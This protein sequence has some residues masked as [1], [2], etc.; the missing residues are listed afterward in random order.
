MK[1]FFR[2][3]RIIF[4]IEKWLWKS[5]ICNLAGL[6]TSS[7]NVQKNFQTHFCDQ[8]E[9]FLSNSIDMVKIL[10][11]WWIE[12]FNNTP[13]QATHAYLINEY[14]YSELPNKQA[15]QDKRVCRDDFTIS[16]MSMGKDFLI[17]YSKNWKY[18]GFF[19]KKKLSIL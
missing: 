14:V 13:A 2:K 3:I 6:I 5:E 8:F 18:G 15:D 1:F 10:H 19:F 9:K 12:K 7:K 11:T 17:R 4:D 16:Y